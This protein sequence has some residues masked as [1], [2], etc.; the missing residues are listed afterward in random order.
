MPISVAI[1]GSG[2]AGF[3]TADALLK[4]CGSCQI[5]IIERLPTPYGLIRG[6]VAPDH[7]T[8][9]KVARKYEMTALIDE[10][11]YY[12]NV[13]VNGDIGLAELRELYDAVVLAVGAPNDRKLTVPGAEKYGVFGSAAFV[14][15][16]NGHPDFRELEPDLNIEAAVVI[17]NGN[18]AIDCAR[19][20]LRS[21]A[22]MAQSDLPDHV[23]EAIH[24]APITDVYL[25]G[26]RGPV[27]AKFTNVELREMGELNQTAPAV[28]ADQL[29]DDIEAAVADLE[30]RDRRL[31]ERNLNTLAGF[32]EKTDT[33]KPKR[34]H[35]E[36]YAQPVEVLGG[37]RV[38]GIR[39]ERTRVVDGRAEGTGEMFDVPCGLVIPAIGYRS[40]AIDGAPFDDARGIIPNN[41]GRVD[42]GLYAVGWIKR[43]PSGVISSNRPDG[44][45]VAQYIAEDFGGVGTD[46]KPGRAGLETIL[47]EREVR[48]ISFDDWR[49][50]DALEIANADGEA[51][52]RKFVTV[53][54]MLDALDADGNGAEA[55][56]G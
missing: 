21:E 29:P 16:Y 47:R 55:V 27:D 4:S 14:G 43:G 11:N 48:W 32:L 38:E 45:I 20:L 7:Q 8:T 1:I 41:D 5:D 44:E 52:R 40:D 13:E 42:D 17:G 34:V 12:G 28:K 39:M 33:S 18:V 30:G 2:P 15:W 3:Y 54:E 35:F 36:F 19:V 50:I 56:S 10:V 24:N 22:G 23:C 46:E 49:R 51:P 53:E 25:M 31:K 9:K 37:E 26:R 6:G